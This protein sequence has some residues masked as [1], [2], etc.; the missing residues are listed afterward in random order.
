MGYR[1]LPN[2]HPDTGRNG[3]RVMERGA[4]SFT[5]GRHVQT[6]ISKSEGPNVSTALPAFRSEGDHWCDHSFQENG[7]VAFPFQ[8]QCTGVESIDCD[9]THSSAEVASAWWL[10]PLKDDG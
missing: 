2:V 1:A 6:S 7:R 8:G 5:R 10:P 9:W 3:S 4:C